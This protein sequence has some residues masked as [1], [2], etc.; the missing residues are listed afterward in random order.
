[1]ASHE[2]KLD[3]REEETMHHGR[4]QPGDDHKVT[5]PLVPVLGII[6]Y[7]HGLLRLLLVVELREKQ[8]LVCGK[9]GVASCVVVLLGKNCP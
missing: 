1:M 8:R 2:D 5:L 7:H 4:I 9:K 6:A 3:L